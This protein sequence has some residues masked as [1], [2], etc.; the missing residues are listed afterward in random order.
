MTLHIIECLPWW[1]MVTPRN[2]PDVNKQIQELQEQKRVQ[3]DR[4][5]LNNIIR[6]V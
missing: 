1:A 6:K 5:I 3:V 4:L 2:K